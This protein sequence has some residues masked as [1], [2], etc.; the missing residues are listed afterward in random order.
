[1]HDLTHDQAEYLKANYSKYSD[2]K[3]ARALHRDKTWIIAAL[4]ALDCQRSRQNLDYIR[5]HHREQPPPFHG[6]SQPYIAAPA[7]VSLPS[8]LLLALAFVIPAMVY[9]ATISTSPA[10]E[11]SAELALCAYGH[12]IPRSPACPI[13]LLLGQVLALVSAKH[14]ALLLNILSALTGAAT[15]WLLAQI[16]YRL[17]RS[18]PAALVIAGLFAFTGGV[19]RSSVTTSPLPLAL[20]GCALSLYYLLVWYETT[21]DSAL[22]IATISGIAA[23]DAHSRFMLLAPL[24]L[25]FLW[26]VYR[27]RRVRSNVIAGAMLLGF[28]CAGVFLYL[29]IKTWNDPAIHQVQ[30]TSFTDFYSYLRPPLSWNPD[31]ASHLRQSLHQ[32]CSPTASWSYPLAIPAGL[33]LFTAWIFGVLRLWKIRKAVAVVCLAAVLIGVPLSTF[34]TPG[35]LVP[36]ILLF[37]AIPLTAALANLFSLSKPLAIPC[38]IILTIVISGQLMANLAQCNYHEWDLPRCYARN[39]QQN[40]TKNAVIVPREQT[41][42]WYLLYHTLAAYPQPDIQPINPYGADQDLAAMLWHCPLEHLLDSVAKKYPGKKIYLTN[43]DIHSHARRYHLIRRG[44][45]WQAIPITHG[46]PAFKV[47]D[48]PLP[49]L[50]I[51]SPALTA[52]E[53]RL[54]SHCHLIRAAIALSQRQ[55]EPALSALDQCL[56]HQG[57]LF[58]LYRHHARQL[59]STRDYAKAMQ[60]YRAL[61]NNRPNAQIYLE[62]ARIENLRGNPAQARQFYEK[63]LEYNPNSANALLELA[64][65][66]ETAGRTGQAAQLYRRIIARYPD[67]VAPYRRLARILAADPGQKQQV[68]QLLAQA[69]QL[70]ARQAQAKPPKVPEIPKVPNPKH[71]PWLPQIPQPG[72]KLPQLPQIPR[73]EIP[74]S[75]Y[76]KEQR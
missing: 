53:R 6:S 16:S 60:L 17:F 4:V 39:V 29:P 76:P 40:I 13:Y 30:F 59:A 31:I 68:Q 9:L 67:L 47:A 73:P 34:A 52:D 8:K 44:L 36:M 61:A 37:T 24:F 65:T 21:A 74:G 42:A 28:L 45:V 71:A 48:E 51:N 12:G 1:M 69:K 50:P 22:V 32:V 26:V 38:A 23:M 55:V 46:R 56:Y 62:M 63:S 10:G 35:P 2:N 27:Q 49:Q 14:F 58:A 20:L 54:L 57:R 75:K 5:T 19:W 43:L 72:P 66:H 18:L 33:L 64:R 3:L 7:L 70:E 15:V 11:N 41:A 25:V